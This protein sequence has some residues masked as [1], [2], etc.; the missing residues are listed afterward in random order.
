MIIMDELIDLIKKSK[1]EF[2]KTLKCEALTSDGCCSLLSYHGDL[3]R[4]GMP[5]V[6]RC[7]Y[8]PYNNYQ[9][10]EFVKA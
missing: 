9:E 1:E 10:C 6:Q 4:G 8:V 7:W 3:W 2:E 5:L